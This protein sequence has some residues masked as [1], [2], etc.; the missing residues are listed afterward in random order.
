MKLT[1]ILAFAFAFSLVACSGKNSNLTSS[2]DQ[3]DMST[4]SQTEL[5]SRVQTLNSSLPLANQ[6]GYVIYS[7]NVPEFSHISTILPPKVS[8]TDLRPLR[9]TS[10][11]KVGNRLFVSYLLE[12]ESVAGALDILDISDLSQPLLIASYKFSNMEFS[13]V[14]VKDSAVYLVG[15]K[16]GNGAVMVTM[17]ISNILEP[18]LSKYTVIPGDVATSMDM[19]QG[20]L[21]VGSAQNGG[22][23]YFNLDVPSNPQFVKYEEKNNVL[24]VKALLK[25]DNDAS[26][27]ITPLVLYGQNST[28]LSMEGNYVELASVQSEAPSRFITVGPLVYAVTAEGLSVTE[29]TDKLYRPFIRKIPVVGQV[30]GVGHLDQ[31]LY[32]AAGDKGLR[33]IDVQEPGSPKEVG[34]LDFE[35]NGSAN[36]VWVERIDSANKLIILADGQSGIRLL[37]EE[38]T[39]VDAASKTIKIHAKST[40]SAGVN[41]KLVVL[42]NNVVVG[43]PIDVSSSDFVTYSVEA[44]N[45]LVFGDQ[46]KV[47]FYNDDGVRNVSIAYIKIGEDFFYQWYNNYFYM[48]GLSV[49]NYDS[50]NILMDEGGYIKLTY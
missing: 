49:H 12:G 11:I 17:D 2:V 40:M 50:D 38:V 42:V 46:V 37:K 27:E 10:S 6:P 48:N 33:L 41:G 15:S 29:L 7:S 13:D 31:K 25:N 14:R 3:V 45:P 9:A 18:T 4:A 19:R 47:E 8:S 21:I 30:H 39:P 1:K 44:S 36:N 26:G 23:S 35:D 43:D 20:Q 22:L 28:A 32:V 34:Y 24:A 5:E 16:K